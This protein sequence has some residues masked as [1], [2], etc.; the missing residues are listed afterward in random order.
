MIIQAIDKDEKNWNIL[1]DQVVKG[2]VIPVIGPEMVRIGNK[3]SIQFLIDVFADYCGITEGTI[4]TF[5]QLIYD[6]RFRAK[7]DDM[8]GNIHELLASTI[9]SASNAEYFDQTDDNNLLMRLLSIKH[10]PFVITTTFDPIVEN[11]MR[12]IH[13]NQLRVKVFRNDPSNNDDI[14]NEAEAQQPTLYYMFGKADGKQGHFVATDID[15]L[16]FSQSWMLPNDSSSLAKPSRLSRLL[17]KRYLL[18]MGY[19]YQDW[20]FR[21][22]WYSMKSDQFGSDKSG[23]MAQSHHDQDLIDFLTRA[24]AFTQVEPDLGK[25]ID[26]LCQGIEREMQTRTQSP[27]RH[28]QVP[29]DGADVFISYSRGDAELVEEVYHILTAKG[30]NVWYDR[31]SMHKGVDFMRQIENAIKNSTFFVPVFTDTITH[32][33]D[34]EHPYRD[35][36]R[37][38]VNHI[39]RIGGIPYCFPFYEIGFD[40]DSLVAAIPDDLKRHDA[41]GFTKADYKERAEEMADYLSNEIEKRRHHG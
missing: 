32:Q 9:G 38:A 28:N 4:N 18:V 5:S 37:F 3:S 29:E 41:F 14:L 15:L 17:A 19:N 24:N 7:S 34:K 31:N 11:M 40:M 39:R 2:N 23:M 22:F 35:E 26:R 6:P 16:K 25:L 13:G 8:G 33:A 12:H 27:S 1:F 10:F 20:L 36:W 30:L 21:F